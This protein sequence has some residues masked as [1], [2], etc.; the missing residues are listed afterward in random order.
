M[1]ATDARIA[2]R[3][4][5]TAFAL[6]KR[7]DGTWRFL[8]VA[9]Q[10]EDAERLAHPRRRLRH[11]AHLGRRPRRLAPAP[12]PARRRPLPRPARRRRHPRALASHLPDPIAGSNNPAAA[13]PASSAAAP[14]GGLRIDGGDAGKR[15]FNPRTVSLTDIAWVI[16]ADADVRDNGGLLDEARV[17]RLRYLEGTPKGS[18]RWIDTGWAIAAWNAGKDRV[19]DPIVARV[20]RDDG[21][22]ID[23]TFRVERIGDTPSVVIESR[24][25]TRGIRA[26]SATPTTPRASS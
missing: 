2:P 3:P 7:A 25:G 12:R 11:V 24:G 9:R 19:R 23:A 20:H 22:E 14:R 18:T 8:G 4:G 6:A 26:P 10:I 16:A 15:G 13:A 17:N 5:E 1:S 21:T